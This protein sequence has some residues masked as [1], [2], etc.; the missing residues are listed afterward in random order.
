MSDMIFVM[1]VKA[2]HEFRY[3]RMNSSAMRA[4]GLNENAYGATFHDVVT[5]QEAEILQG[6]YTKALVERKPI[7]FIL[8][9][10]ADSHG[11]ISHIMATVRDIT[12]QY[13]QHEPEESKFPF[14]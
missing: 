9:P 5:A 8:N 7:S 2:N 12:K 14:R 3:A 11:G 1:A 4:S 10:I 13:H 6:Y